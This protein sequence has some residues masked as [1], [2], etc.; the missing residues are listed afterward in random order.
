MQKAENS[1]LANIADILLSYSLVCP[2]LLDDPN[3]DL[4]FVGKLEKHTIDKLTLKDYFNSLNTTTILWSLAKNKNKDL[5][6]AFN[7]DVSS[8]LIERSVDLQPG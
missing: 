7:Q 3:S 1:T 8:C 5:V 4:N 6:P 2:G